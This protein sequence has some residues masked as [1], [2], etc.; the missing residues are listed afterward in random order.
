INKTSSRDVK[1]TFFNIF[2]QVGVQLKLA[3]FNSSSKGE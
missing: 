2:K 3:A 1:R